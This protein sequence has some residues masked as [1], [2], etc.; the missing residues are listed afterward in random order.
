MG[1]PQPHQQP[2]TLEVLA[3]K[4][5]IVQEGLDRVLTRLDGTASKDDVTDLKVRVRVLEDDRTR[6]WAVIGVVGFLGV[7][8]LGALVKWMMTT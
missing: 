2:V 8:C 1:L 6:A 5:T 4:I 7:G 3:F